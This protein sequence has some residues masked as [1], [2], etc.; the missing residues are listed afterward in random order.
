MR[1]NSPEK[2][3]ERKKMKKNSKKMKKNMSNEREDVPT[4]ID[5]RRKLIE[6]KLL[7]LAGKELDCPCLC[8]RVKVVRLSIKEIAFHASKSLASTAVALDLPYWLK[9]ARFFKCTFP[10]KN[11]QQELF[12]FAFMYE[13]HADTPHGVAKIMVGVRNNGRFLQYCITV[14]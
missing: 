13:L 7:A 12:R 14:I 1:K 11:R 2:R 6:K 8:V 4:R 3:P 10:K 9:I 5:D